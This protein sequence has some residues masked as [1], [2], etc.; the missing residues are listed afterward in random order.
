M[1]FVNNPMASSRLNAVERLARAVVPKQPSGAVASPDRHNR[2]ADPSLAICDADSP[3]PRPGNVRRRPVDRNNS[4]FPIFSSATN[5]EKL[6]DESTGM[7][8]P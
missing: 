5:A 3:K 8:K 7:V 6:D 1:S 4:S 2:F